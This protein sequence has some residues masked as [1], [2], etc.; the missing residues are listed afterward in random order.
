MK[1]HKWFCFL[2]VSMV[3]GNQAYA[4]LLVSPT[5]VAFE[6]RDR[7]Q[8]VVLINTGDKKRT[9]RVE[10]HE[11]TADEG[12][13]YRDVT[14]PN[15]RKA[16]EYIRY[17][18]RQVTLNP[19]ERQ[20]IKLMARKK[21]DMVN[22]EYRSHL[23]FVVLPEQSELEQQAPAEGVSM[24][25]NLF[26][27]YSI[28]VVL[29]KGDDTINPIIEDLRMTRVD[30]DKPA[31]RVLLSKD[32]EYGAI[33]NV[34]AYFKDNANNL[35]QLALLNNINFFHEQN[36]RSVNLVPTA[37]LPSAEGTIVVRYIGVQEFAGKVLAEK[38]FPNSFGIPR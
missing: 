35:T 38:E 17:S 3:M 18:P 9:Y 34:I 33:G 25:L 1:L 13:D 8:Q 11:F 6:E 7:T 28:P 12:G 4:S 36:T 32:S 2:A 30:S 31:Y 23:K 16:S 26:L 22:G 29:K 5:R 14:D 21:N 19:G 15:F 27:S 24:K 37:D 20:V 10:W